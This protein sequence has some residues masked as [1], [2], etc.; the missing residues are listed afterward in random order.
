VAVALDEL[1]SSLETT[2]KNLDLMVE[3]GKRP[4][5]DRLK[6][7]EQLEEAK[8]QRESVRADRVKVGATLLALLGRDPA[9]QLE[10][11]PLPAS[12]PSLATAAGDLRAALDATSPIRRTHASREQA[13][14]GVDKA[15]SAFL[16]K[17]VASASYFKDDAPSL[18]EAFDTWQVTLGVRVP[19]LHGGS[20]FERLAAARELAASA[21]RSEEQVRLQLAAELEE[22][23]AQLRA[24]K[25]ELQAAQARVDAG[26]EAARIE[27]IR[28]D[29][30][31]GSIEDLLRAETRRSAARASLARARGQVVTA[32]ERINSLVEEEAV[33]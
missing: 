14:E 12:L 19:L 5:I 22:A 7:V 18:D 2:H 33:R 23:L 30:G 11:D 26:E 15:Y 6:V 13:E 10:V 4:E 31:A 17:V 21:E 8:A 27:A 24:R 1:V 28:Y 20:R 32:A 16:P 29:T 25:A 9:A 3:L